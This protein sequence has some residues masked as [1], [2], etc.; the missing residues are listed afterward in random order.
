LPQTT[1]VAEYVVAGGYLTAELA[2]CRS[3]GYGRLRLAVWVR[4]LRRRN[5]SG[6][7]E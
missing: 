7:E 5:G 1:P 4:R 2:A 6:I 3:P